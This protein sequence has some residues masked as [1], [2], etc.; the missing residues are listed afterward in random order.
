MSSTLS[1]RGFIKRVG[2]TAV[3]LTAASY[4]R[5]L[6]ANERIRLGIIGCGSRGFGAHM[7]GVHKHDRDQ[8]VQFT[9]VCDPW[10]LSRERAAQAVKDWYGLKARQFESY[11]DLLAF[12]DIDAVMIASCD[13]QHTTHL[14][15]T[16]KTG[17]DV[18]VEKPI[19]LDFDRVRKACDAVKAAN[20]VC[21]V[22]TQLRSEASFTG[23]KE[24]YQTGILGT[25]SRIEQR[26]NGGT[27]YWYSWMKRSIN[28][29]KQEEVNWREFTMHR[30]LRPYDPVQ[31]TGWYGFRNYTDGPVANLGCHFIDLVHY[32]TGAQYPSTCVC[33]GGQF[34]WKDDYRFTCPD[35]VQALWIYPD[36]F[37]VSYSTNFGNS[38]DGTY[39]RI[40]GDQGIIRSEGGK[41]LLTAEGG[42]RNKGVIRG[43][44]PV[45]EVERPD[46]F[47]DWL[48]CLRTRNQPIAPI[49]AGYQHSVACLMAVQSF[50]SGQR[51]T[52]DTNKREIVA[53]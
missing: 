25:V 42:I 28:K 36:G 41:L 12:E 40:H 46:H 52:Y 5:V 17:K 23:C 35:H 21:Q 26:R 14:E 31:F 20:L 30:T 2:G 38:S 48:Q 37:M 6:G 50:D 22:G 27:P 1:R 44:K 19:G 32:I 7:Q 47:L 15:A 53:G 43:E 18:Y 33:H 8:N 16:A 10:K 24:L 11:E 29:I 9:A 3:A 49:E 39:L 51:M 4:R 45:Q 34:T 13:H